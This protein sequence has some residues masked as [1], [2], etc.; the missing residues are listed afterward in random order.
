MEP[1]FLFTSFFYSFLLLTSG[2]VGTQGS[3]LHHHHRHRHHHHHR[4]K[5]EIYDHTSKPTKLFVFGDSY[6]DTGN[7]RKSLGN[8]WK[9]PYGSTFPGKPAGRFSDGRVLTD[10]LAKF[11]GLKSPLA[12]TWMKLGGK[13]LR[14]GMNFAFGGSGVFNT[15]GDLLPNM[16]TQIDFFQKLMDDSFYTKWD[17]ESSV[18]LVALAGNDYGAYVGNGG[19]IEGLQSFIPR[20]INQ[21]AVNLKRIH[22]LGATK[23]I[24]TSLEPLGC[25]PRMTLLSSFQQCNTT[26]NLAVSYHNLLLQQTVDRLNNETKSS[27]FFILD[28]YTSFTTLLDQK[29][30]YQGNFDLLLRENIL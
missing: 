28:L 29:G 13:K 22:G 19:T 25:L 7:T 17:L 9:E 11:L 30:N 6:A 24:V 26:Q 27:T 1:S 16:T 5:H 10:Y 18:V 8:S 21:L 20:V 23:V 3:P 4:E 2:Y 15:L 12:Y 14:N